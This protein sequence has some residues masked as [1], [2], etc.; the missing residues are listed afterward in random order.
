MAIHK[1]KQL[2]VVLS[3]A[4]HDPSSGAG[5]TADIKTIAAH[6]CYGVT[7]VTAL[8]VQSTRGVKRVDPMEGQLITE[9]LEQLMDD[10]DI[11]AVKIGML[12]SVEAAK[13]VA[14]FLK[15]YW[16]KFVVLDPIVRSSSGAELISREGLQVLKDRLLSRVYVAT[17]NIDEAAALTGLNVTTLDE[18]QLAAQRLHEM[19]A[20]NV[21]ITGGHI[22]PPNDLLS[23]EGK[24]PAIIS[25]RKIPG[26]S[27]HGTGCAFSTALACNLALGNDL[28]TAAK[29]AKRFVEA[30]L[31]KAPAIGKGIGPVI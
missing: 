3:I 23:Q 8:T 4:G 13:S 17:P 14:A 2:P 22:D 12:G 29:A 20:R 24:K 11:A 27:T 7:C 9:T 21:I 31:R 26:R 10:L 15:R 28:T 6:G 25:G 1:K 5:I 16:L 30:A 18:M 19:G